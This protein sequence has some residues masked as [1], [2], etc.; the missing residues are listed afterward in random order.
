MPPEPIPSSWESL[1]R[2]RWALFAVCALMVLWFVLLAFLVIA[3]TSHYVEILCGQRSFSSLLLTNS[4]LPVCLGYGVAHYH[5]GR[6]LLALA[7]QSKDLADGTSLRPAGE[8][9]SSFWKTNLRAHLLLFAFVV[10]AWAMLS[11]LR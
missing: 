6:Q 7:R 8:A 2:S 10:F 4:L 5:V 3:T 9:F 1:R 11:F